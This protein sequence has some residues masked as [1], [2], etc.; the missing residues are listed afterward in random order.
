VLVHTS[1][2]LDDLAPAVGAALYRIAQEAV[3]NAVRHAPDATEVTVEVEAHA[4]QVRLTVRDDGEPVTAGD[5]TPGYGLVG[6]RER[7]ELLGGTLRAGPAPGGGWSVEATLPAGGPASA[8]PRAV[9]RS[10]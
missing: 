8:R 3:T 6:M 10:S 9:K 1:G 2:D 7:A 5:P 4:D